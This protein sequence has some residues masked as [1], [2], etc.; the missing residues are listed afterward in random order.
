MPAYS[1]ARSIAGFAAACLFSS[2]VEAAPQFAGAERA[3]PAPGAVVLTWQPARGDDGRGS[4]TYR[5]YRKAGD[6]WDFTRSVGE[7]P[8]TVWAVTGLANGTPAEFIVRARDTTGEDTNTRTVRATPTAQLRSEEYRGIWIT[9][10]E[11]PSG[12]ANVL[13]SRFDTMMRSL[14]AGNFNAVVFQVRGQGDTLYPSRDEPWSTIVSPAARNFNPTAYALEQAHANGLEFHAW[15]N[16]SVIW[17]SKGKQ[18]PAAANHPFYKFA[19]ARKP[20]TRLGLVH[21]AKG[22]PIQWGSDDYVWLTHGNPDVNAYV[23]RQVINFLDAHPKVDGLH[24]DDRTSMWMG[25][26]RDPVSIR[27]FGGRGNPMGIKD[28]G[29]WQRDQLA[30]CLSDIYTQAKSRNPR[31]LVSASPFG[32]FDKRRIPGYSRYSDCLQFGKNPE[33]WMQMGIL[34]A[35]MPQIYWGLTDPKRPNYGR[36]VMDWVQ[37]NKSGRPIWPGSN[38]NNAPLVPEQQRYVAISRAFGCWGNQL[39]SWSKAT[40][41]QWAN[42]GRAIYPTKARV[43]V[44]AHMRPGVFG[45]IMGTIRSGSGAPI[46]D[47]WIMLE[48]RPY[49]HLSSSDGFYGIPNLK[50]GRYKILFSNAPGK[51]VAREVT[52]EADKTAVVD[53]VL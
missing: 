35:L 47:A 48:G 5:V 9:R 18:L 23:R 10:F 17:Q 40:P 44:P 1:F 46:T 51:N 21:D 43:P 36:L 13:R 14:S 52:V 29:E 6:R 38:L 33:A 4:V 26:S 45:Q 28:L 42:Q 50:P 30:R 32:I 3:L 8:G 34:D 24:W 25:V 16:L 49:I 41:E 7:T 39:F 37:N 27:R 22:N 15:L 11:W 2:A 19:D 20:E 31:I 12:D 53:M